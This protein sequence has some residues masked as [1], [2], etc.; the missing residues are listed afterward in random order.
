[1]A[2]PRAFSEATTAAAGSTGR[3]AAG[4]RPWRSRDMYPEGG[5]TSSTST[6]GMPAFEGLLGSV[7]GTSSAT[8]C[9]PWWRLVTTRATPEVGAGPSATPSRGCGMS[10]T[11]SV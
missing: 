8:T 7:L 10:P 5:D 2:A 6:Q 11:A 4:Y 9:A 3:G 1:M